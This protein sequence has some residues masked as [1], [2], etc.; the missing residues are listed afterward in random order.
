MPA[1]DVAQWQ[2]APLTYEPV[3][4]T[5]DGGPLP[6]GFHHLRQ[7]YVV[8]H[9]DAAFAHAAT[10]LMTWQ[11]HRR[12]GM[13]VSASGHAIEPDEVVLCRLGPLR[14]PCRVLWVRD[15]PDA[16]GFGYGTLPGHPEAG[17]EAFVVSRARDGLVS[18]SVTAYSVPGMLL[19]RLAGPVGRLGQQVMVGRYAEALR[20]RD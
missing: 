18:L 11:M 5:H 8:G 12:A 4:A 3:G 19:T 14:V 10:V 6:F 16:Q 17:E 1:D 7:R 13:R 20:L 2:S 15:E 9:G